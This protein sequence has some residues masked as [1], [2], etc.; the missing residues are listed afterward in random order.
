MKKFALLLLAA[1]LALA[2]CGS[3]TK[4]QVNAT[5]KVVPVAYVTHAAT[6]TA[7]LKSEHVVLTGK[8]SGGGQT[9]Y[10]HGSGDFANSPLRGS[11][12]LS[13]ADGSDMQREV[14]TGATLYIRAPWTLGHQRSDTPWGKVDGAQVKKALHS[15]EGLAQNP[16]EFL[17]QIAAAGSVRSLGTEKVDGVE[18]T[19]YQAANLDISK[20][21]RWGTT[22]RRTYGP[23]DVWVGKRDGYVYRE[24]VS[25][26]STDGGH[27]SGYAF[28]ADFSRFNEAVKVTV[29][30]TSET[31]D[32]G[33][34]FWP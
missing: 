15:I 27:R 19:H 1:P 22:G 10:L 14:L 20:L 7:A 21:S 25:V 18:T 12:G 8:I 29:P 9:N 6:K 24:S 11:F 13:L 33:K 4:A 31:S 2:A 26:S 28:R 34:G 16:V 32:I 30:P 5:A 17:R 3:S 23:I